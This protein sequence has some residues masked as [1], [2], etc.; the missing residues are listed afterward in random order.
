MY[1]YGGAD[2][3]KGNLGDLLRNA[4]INNNYFKSLQTLTFE[5]VIEEVQKNVTCC[6]PWV[7]GANGVPSTLF[8]CLYRLIN[9]KLTEK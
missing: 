4:I 1:S 5:E 2:K 3:L 9:L 8:C 7:I 6:E